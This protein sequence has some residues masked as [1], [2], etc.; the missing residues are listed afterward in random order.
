MKKLMII[1]F[2]TSLN[3]FA[4]DFEPNQVEFNINGNPN[5]LISADSALFKQNNLILGWHWGGGKS[6][7]NPLL[8]FS[9]SV[10]L[11]DKNN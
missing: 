9:K 11:K 7:T 1:I 2:L 6:M 4:Q 3:I 8:P 10:V 5:Y